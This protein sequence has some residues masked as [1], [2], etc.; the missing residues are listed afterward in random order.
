MQKVAVTSGKYL[1]IAKVL[2]AKLIQDLFK[3]T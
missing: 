2:C 1:N 3:M